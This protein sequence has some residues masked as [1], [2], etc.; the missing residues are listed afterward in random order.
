VCL[1]TPTRTYLLATNVK[2]LTTAI[3][4]TQSKADKIIYFASG[5]LRYAASMLVEINIGTSMS[6]VF[7]KTPIM[8]KTYFHLYGLSNLE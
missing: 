3:P 1:D 6:E 7:T 2:D 4:T 8:A 5:F